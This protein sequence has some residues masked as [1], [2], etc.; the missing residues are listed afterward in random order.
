MDSSSRSEELDW[1]RQ[2]SRDLDEEIDEEDDVI[3]QIPVTIF[4]VP[5]TLITIKQEAYTPQEVSIGPYHHRRP[6]LFEMER[7]KVA[8]AKNIQKQLRDVKFR[9]IVERFSKLDRN[10][11]AFYER[12][13]DMDGERLAWLSAVDAAFLLEFLQSYCAKDDPALTRVSSRMFHLVDA[14]RRKSM[15]RA[16]LRDIIMLENQIPLFLVI[17]LLDFYKPKNSNEILMKMLMGFYKDLS[18]IKKMDKFPRYKEEFLARAHLLE[19]LYYVIVPMPRGGSVTIGIDV[20]EEE[21]ETDPGCCGNAGNFLLNVVSAPTRWLKGLTSLKTFKFFVE[22]PLKIRNRL[23]GINPLLDPVENLLSTVEQVANE[24]QAPQ[25]PLQTTLVEELM[26]P[27]VTDLSSIGIR[28]SPAKGGLETIQFDKVSATFYLPI[29]NLDDTS[30]VVL[31]NLIAY[32]ASVAPDTTVFTRYIE[33]MNGIIDGEG[34]V[35]LLREAGVM[36]NHLK[37]DVEAVT[38]WSDLSNSVTMT[39]VPDLDKIIED[40]NAFYS[41]NWSVKAEGFMRKYVFGAWPLLTFIAANLLLLLTAL[42]TFCSLYDCSK[43]L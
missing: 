4:N 33:L 42:G 13:L 6:E 30:E 19:F 28:F 25:D 31:R 27:S 8:S 38:L 20:R 21:T 26:I 18:P 14:N 23:L 34:D 5:K 29:I 3:E 40:I 39:K 37:S 17:G 35:K 10:I 1:V 9:N 41:A 12:Y 32:E 36:L 24:A 11:R 22:F 2:I 15:S 16:I 43:W 7:Y